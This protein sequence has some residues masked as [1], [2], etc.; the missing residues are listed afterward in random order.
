VRSS[1][2]NL[3]IAGS[4]LA[5]VIAT[6]GM[7]IES[8]P[9]Y[10]I[11]PGVIGLVMMIVSSVRFFKHKTDLAGF[12]ATVCGFVFYQ[13]FQAN[14]LTLREFSNSI[15]AIAPID[16]NL[17]IF[18]GNFTTGLVLIGYRIV[19]TWMK[20]PLR[21]LV[22]HPGSASRKNIDP[23]VLVGFLVVFSVVALPNVFLGRVVMGAIQNIVYQRATASAPE[24]FAGFETNGG[25]LAASALNMTLWAPSMFFLW[26]YL[27]KSRYRLTMLVLSPLVLLWTASVALQGARTYLVI[28]GFGLI[29]YY[30]GSP[31]FGGKIITLGS[32]LGAVMLIL[33]QMASLFRGEGLGAFDAAELSSHLFE[34]RGNEGTSNQMDGLEFFR[35]ELLLKGAAPNPVI[36][37]VRGIV[38]RPIEGVLMPLPRRFFPWKPFD[39]S[40]D[41]F[42]VFF[43]NVRLGVP[44]DEPFLGASPGLIG[45]EL[46]RYGFLGPLTVFLW[47]GAILALADQLYAV[48]S[49]SDF[50]RI[51][52]T[53][54]VTFFVAEMRDWVPLWFL[55]FLPVMLVLGYVGWKARRLPPGP[56]RNRAGRPP[57]GP[58]RL[59]ASGIVE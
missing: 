53:V 16:R 54:L 2:H 10:G 5:A 31:R 23:M 11:F 42:S 1:L 27:L 48:G 59:P 46:I 57:P 47:L 18:F 51:F 25:P 35:T 41:D 9:I 19:S 34:V 12:V 3:Y 24:S 38:E 8:P 50:H 55:P 32:L 33:I 7:A 14:P 36:G 39:A 17:G 4:L 20:R 43:Q 37:F 30:L 15:A 6:L 45:R 22:P 28:V 56:S 21:R 58:R 26:L 52:A 44:S 29:I 49:H 13:A 40:A